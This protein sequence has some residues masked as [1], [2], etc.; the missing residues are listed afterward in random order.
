MIA[1][2]TTAGTISEYANGQSFGL[3]ENGNSYAWGT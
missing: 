2:M 3:A 1:R